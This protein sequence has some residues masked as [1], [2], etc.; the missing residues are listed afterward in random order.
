MM[1]DLERILILGCSSPR[2]IWNAYANMIDVL[3][4]LNNATGDP[5]DCLKSLYVTF[6]L[7]CNILALRAG[8]R[9]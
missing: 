4:L 9:L 7:Q 2:P 5:Y 6:R 1:V 8:F 3:A